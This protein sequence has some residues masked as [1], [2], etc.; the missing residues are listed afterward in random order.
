LDFVN[1]ADEPV[2][3]LRMRKLIVLEAVCA[4]FNIVIRG[5]C[6]VDLVVWEVH[7]VNWFTA[8]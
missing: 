6:K 7:L 8:T 2:G 4:T 3:T 1:I 5:W